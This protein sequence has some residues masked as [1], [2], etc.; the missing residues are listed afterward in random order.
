M[1][2]SD[3]SVLDKEAGIQLYIDEHVKFIENKYD[4]F[5]DTHSFNNR[6]RQYDN[7]DEMFWYEVWNFVGDV[8]HV[9]SFDFGGV[10]A[11]ATPYELSLA[12]FLY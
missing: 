10:S 8:G 1:M 6:Y 11:E 9:M 2:T 12:D 3:S 4:D 7:G 5:E